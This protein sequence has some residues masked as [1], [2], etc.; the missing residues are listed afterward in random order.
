MRAE[1]R[2][3][4]SLTHTLEC[5]PSVPSHCDVPSLTKMCKLLLYK[6]THTNS[7]ALAH[8]DSPVICAFCHHS[9]SICRVL[10]SK[11]MRSLYF[12]MQ[13]ASPRFS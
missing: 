6:H 8:L 7:D 4:S 1:E 13:V 2:S 10:L 9:S 3:T 11:Q 5:P 12:L